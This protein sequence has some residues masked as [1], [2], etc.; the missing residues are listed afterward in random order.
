MA[1]RPAP[2]ESL[3]TM[4]ELL[5]QMKLEQQEEKLLGTLGPETP[6]AVAFTDEAEDAKPAEEP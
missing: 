1:Q 2:E 4:I 5:Q 3:D 6:A